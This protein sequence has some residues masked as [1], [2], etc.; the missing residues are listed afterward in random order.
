MKK[1]GN[2]DFLVV[3]LYVDDI[4]YMGSCESI[5]AKFK[6][7]MMSKFEMSDLGML[8]YFLG[9]EI[10]Q[11]LDGIFILQ[12]KYATELLQ[13]FNLL[14]CNPSPTPMNMNEKLV[15]EDG[16]GA[17]NASYFRSLVGGLNYFSHTRPDI[18]FSVSLISRFMHSPSKQHLGAAKRILRYVAGT[19][20][21]GI[22]Y[23]KV[24]DFRLVGFT[25]SDWA[26]SL[27]DCKSTSGNV[28]N[29]G[30]GAISWSSKK[31]DIVALSSSEAEYM[32][33]T[34]SSCQ[35]VWLRKLLADLQQEQIGPTEIWCDNKA[36]IAMTKN[37]AFHSRTKHIDTRYHFIHNLVIG[38]VISME[39][40]GTNDQVA[41]VLT[42]SLPRNKHDFF[43]LQMGVYDFEERGSVD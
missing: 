40:C 14:N 32:A 37:P 22:F 12:R 5:V 10:K 15:L 29:L 21:Y 34:T 28:F 43:R 8:H 30:S 9:L 13:R 2:G 3:C 19:T 4:I 17:A 24:S 20:S 6:N 25:D 27:D 36:T 26:G 7:C 1:R 42:K 35:A 38:G 11:G 16:T 23:S 39:F 31:Q 18:A 33:A 41:D